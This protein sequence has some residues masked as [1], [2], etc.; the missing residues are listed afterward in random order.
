MKFVEQ[1]L[2]ILSFLSERKNELSKIATNLQIIFHKWCRKL[3]ETE[4]RYNHN[5]SL[6]SPKD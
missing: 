3:Q 2:N 5:L 4:L 1:M 6:N